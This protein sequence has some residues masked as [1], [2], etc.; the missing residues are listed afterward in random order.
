MDLESGHG[1]TVSSTQGS[2][3][4]LGSPSSQGLV[5]EAPLVE[6]LQWLLGRSISLGVVGWEGSVY[7][8]A[9]G[10]R[11]ASMSCRTG[12]ATERPFRG[13]E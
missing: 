12:F 2:S 13:S 1:F 9:L 11:L 7:S 3:Q 8:L 5:E 4:R 10:S 6:T